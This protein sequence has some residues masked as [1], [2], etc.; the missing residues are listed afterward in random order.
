M[1]LLPISVKIVY[2]FASL[3]SLARNRELVPNLLGRILRR[4]TLTWDRY[5]GLTLELTVVNV[6][7]KTRNA[8]DTLQR[9]LRGCA[10]RGGAGGYVVLFRA[11]N[12]ASRGRVTCSNPADSG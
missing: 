2:T 6:E 12:C 10:E 4:I 8:I 1:A 3:A 9:E 7:F 5:I 11:S